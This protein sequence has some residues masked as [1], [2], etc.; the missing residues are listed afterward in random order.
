MQ[1]FIYLLTP[2][3]LRMKKIFSIL[4]LTSYLFISCKKEGFSITGHV[5]GY[6][7]GTKVSFE[8]YNKPEEKYYAT[9]TNNTFRF[10][11]FISENEPEKFLIMI[12]NGKDLP[13]DYCS[14]FMENEDVI[15]N[16]HKKDFPYRVKI[17]GS[18]HQ[19]EANKLNSLLLKDMEERDRVSEEYFAISKE[20]RNTDSIKELYDGK[21]GKFTI[22]ENRLDNTLTGFIKNNPNSY[23]ALDYLISLREKFSPKDVK[24]IYEGMNAKVRNGKYGKFIKEYI[25]VSKSKSN[26]AYNF[27]AEDQD[28]K[29]HKMHDYLSK[30]KYTLLEFSRPGCG[31]C[32]KAIPIL[33]DIH[34]EQN[35]N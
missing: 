13:A 16:A 9:I 31:W 23:V 33:E 4:L 5:T 17:T 3:N 30:E 27:E 32:K 15:I 11:G 2:T 8:A 12:D 6:K 35:T 24:Y 14:V 29:F 25:Q 26:V 1:G 7:D 19:D 34:K 18:K 21:N 20:S 22:I 28:G 10:K